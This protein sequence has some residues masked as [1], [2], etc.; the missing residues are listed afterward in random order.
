M[1]SAHDLVRLHALQGEMAIK[2]DWVA[3]GH[4]QALIDQLAIEH[5]GFGRANFA[6]MSDIS[7]H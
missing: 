6:L 5:D 3:V 1:R 2:R 4:L 7:V